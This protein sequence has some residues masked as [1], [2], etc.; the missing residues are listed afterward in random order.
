MNSLDLQGPGERWRALARRDAAADGRFVYAVKTTG[1]FCRPSCPS[2]RPLA[3]NVVYF[4]TPG[5]AERAGF[6]P[7]RRCH[8]ERELS[9]RD[10][11][12]ARVRASCRAIET[13]EAPPRLT[14]LAAAA[15]LSRFHFQ[16]LFKREVGVTPRE[17][18]V[19]HRRERFQRALAA[20]E[21][22]D[23]AVYGAGFGSASRVYE[24]A[25]A[26]L[27]MSPAV[28]ARGAA[29]EQIRCGFARSALGWI[30]VA[31]T[32]RGVCAIEL[33]SGRAAL[34]ERLAERF[35]R[36]AIDAA[37]S[38]LGTYLAAIVAFIERPAQ[39]LR[40]PLDIRGTAFQ[41]RVW[42]ALQ[43]VP[44]GETTSYGALARSVGRPAAARAVAR[45]CATNPVALA[46]P[47]HRAIAADGSSGGYRWG[48][49]RKRALLE[50]ERA[51]VARERGESPPAG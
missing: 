40:L 12:L 1:V 45:A 32:D 15:G 5:A 16:R 50:R 49:Q 51:A 18:Y 19:A 3:R 7:C 33:G 17:Y 24:R 11:T 38:S 29:G 30:A 43:S 41:Q 14:A 25:D 42:R 36:A 48:V 2:R 44:P 31:A 23:A 9:P 35:P 10:D 27:G 26:L 47:C 28:Y 22:V 8:P 20:G 37:D 4:D 39:A 13:A 6:R 46:I 21:S 34:A